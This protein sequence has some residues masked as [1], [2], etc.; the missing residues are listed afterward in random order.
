LAVLPAVADEQRARPAHR[1]RS[2]PPRT[3]DGQ[4][5]CPRVSLTIAEPQSEYQIPELRP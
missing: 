5:I 2:I 1:Q 4:V 3:T